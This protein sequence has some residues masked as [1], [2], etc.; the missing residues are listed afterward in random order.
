ML[1]DASGHAFKEYGLSPDAIHVVI[2]RPDGV[3]GAFVKGTEG[4][5]KYFNTIM[6]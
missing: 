5:N 1:R 6:A 4:V 3:I 2:V